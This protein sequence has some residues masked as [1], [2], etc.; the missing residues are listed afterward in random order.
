MYIYIYICIISLSLSIHIYMYYDAEDAG[1]DAS[2]SQG[3]CWDDLEDRA[4][5]ALCS[6]H[7][8]QQ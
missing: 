1:S 6:I 3:M 4:K 2:S 5:V 7:N 8:K